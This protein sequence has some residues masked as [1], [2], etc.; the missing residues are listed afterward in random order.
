MRERVQALGIQTPEGVRFSLLLAGPVTRMLAWL[1]DA[2]C[3]YVA[4][5]LTSTFMSVFGI[6]FFDIGRGFYILGTFIVPIGYTIAMEWLWRG[7]TI[8]K[9]VL[10]LRVVDVSGLKLQFNQV[11]IRNL[12]RA[13][14]SLPVFYMVGG[15]ST[16][17]SSRAQRLGDLAANTI[18]IRNPSTR[19]PDLDR[20]I[21]DKYNSLKE[22]PH[23]VARLRRRASLTESSVA[24]RAVM[25]RDDFEPDA[26]R[27]LFA[28][29]AG[30]F[31][32]LVTFPPEAV[33]G[34]TDERY[35][36]DVVEVLFKED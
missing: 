3:I 27:E 19:K 32:S 1:V 23:L 16:L 8:G 22:Y 34:I 9:R 24:L 11:V 33:A 35:V 18:V 13:V 4:L 30:H 25:R 10:R 15:I 5:T 29:I 12:L 21:P 2:G 20:L 36:V 31:R 26:R 28:E 7:Q 17:L 14:D 6:L